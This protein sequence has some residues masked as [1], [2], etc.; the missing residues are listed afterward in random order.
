MKILLT[1]KNSYISNSIESWLLSRNK[2]IEIDKISLRSVSLA[3]LSLEPYH[4]IVHTAALVHKKEANYKE[5]DY[6]KANVDLTLALAEKAKKAGVQQFVFLSTMSVFGLEGS[7]ERETI[8]NDETSLQ[9]KSFYGKSKLVAEQELLKMQSDYF[10]IAILR[11]PMVYGPGCPGNYQFLSKFA[12]K[13]PLFPFIKNTRSMIFIDNLCEF[14]RLLIRQQLSGIFHPQDREFVCTSK[15]VEEIAEVHGKPM[16]LSKVAGMLI[17]SGFKN[18]GAAKKIFGNLTY[19]PE[20]SSFNLN[21]HVCDF[22]EAIKK[23]ELK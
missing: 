12:K 14:I 16:Y 7:I 13:A 22:K 20:I 19:S 2:D 21:Y 11:P 23:S 15:M 3:T 17:T 6:F 10:K 9:P 4:V 1:A 8:I 5:S 18:K